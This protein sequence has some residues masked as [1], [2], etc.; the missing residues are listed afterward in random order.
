[1]MACLVLAMQN[2]TLPCYFEKR[3]LSAYGDK[4]IWGERG[5]RVGSYMSCVGTPVLSPGKDISL[6]AKVES[7]CKGFVHLSFVSS[8][9]E[10][11]CLHLFRRQLKGKRS[12]VSIT[13]RQARYP[14]VRSWC[15]SESSDTYLQAG[16]RGPGA[17]ASGAEDSSFVNVTGADEAVQS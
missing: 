11:E 1:M 13:D 10:R 6:A 9:D 8:H 5:R 2:P 4:Y 12:T 7:V 3:N 17:V 16:R 15:R 14:G